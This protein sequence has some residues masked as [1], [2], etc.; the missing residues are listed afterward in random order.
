M[1]LNK[2]SYH[3]QENKIILIAQENFL[4]I[5]SL[6]KNVVDMVLLKFQ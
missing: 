3:S 2:F 4:M 6:V 1:G 5:V